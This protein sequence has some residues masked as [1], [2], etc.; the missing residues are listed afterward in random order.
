MHGH[1]LDHS[2]LVKNK[3]MNV[4]KEHQ[5]TA[6]IAFGENAEMSEDPHRS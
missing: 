3:L 6:Q 4:I 2:G 5:Q 1:K